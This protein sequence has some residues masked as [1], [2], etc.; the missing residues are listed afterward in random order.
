MCE[1]CGARHFFAVLPDR[2]IYDR[3][4]RR[5]PSEYYDDN[6]FPIILLRARKRSQPASEDE[7]TLSGPITIFERKKRFSSDELGTIFSRSKGKCHLCGHGWALADHGRR[8]WHVDHVIPNAGGGCDTENIDNFLVACARCNLKKGRGYTSRT[9]RLA[10][11]EL[12]EKV[13]G[14]PHVRNSSSS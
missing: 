1:I 7:S 12:W 5:Y 4:T 6:E 8:G 9:V 3:D 13:S 11:Q 10:V 14:M 2:V